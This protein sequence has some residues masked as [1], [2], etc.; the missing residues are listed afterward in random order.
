VRLRSR[1]G[2]GSNVWRSRP[3]APRSDDDGHRS[4]V[5]A[6]LPECQR[7]ASVVDDKTSRTAHALAQ[8][9]QPPGPGFYGLRNPSRRAAVLSRVRPGP[10]R[11]VLLA[12]SGGGVCGLPSWRR[13]IIACTSQSRSPAA[14]FTAPTPPVALCAQPAASLVLHAAPSR[15]GRCSSFVATSSTRV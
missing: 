2:S 15:A 1:A 14:A 12:R 8:Q 10:S 11:L 4:A 9:P 5:F 3:T 6:R 7:V 13:S